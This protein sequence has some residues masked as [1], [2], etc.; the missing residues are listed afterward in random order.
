MV[1][2]ARVYSHIVSSSTSLLP[3]ELQAVEHGGKQLGTASRPAARASGAAKGSE[4]VSDVSCACQLLG[5]T[6]MSTCSWL[7]WSGWNSLAKAVPKSKQMQHSCNVF[8]CHMGHMSVT[9]SLAMDL[10][11]SPY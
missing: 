5:M 2:K 6:H 1:N 11:L 8:T 7:P 9:T 10:Q 4:P 3:H